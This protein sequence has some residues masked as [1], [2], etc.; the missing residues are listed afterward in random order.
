MVTERAFEPEDLS[1][2]M[3]I[4]TS[5]IRSLAALWYLPEQ[6]AAWA[7]AV[8]DAERWR[9]RLAPLRTIVAESGGRLAGFTSYTLEG[10]LD[11][12]FT[13]PDFAR[14]GVATGLYERVEAA[15]RAVRVSTITT[16][17]S[18]AARPFFEGRGFQV[19]ADESVEVR[20]VYL[21]RFAMHKNLE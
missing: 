1:S 18:L 13:H 9:K 15:L 16:H 20:G 5:S 10:Y 7:P 6:I 12:L 4:Y 14:R 19:D 17:A 2:V 21:R 11:L 3:E 8:P